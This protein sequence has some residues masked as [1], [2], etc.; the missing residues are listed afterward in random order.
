MSY[1][2][3]TKLDTIS[4]DKELDTIHQTTELITLI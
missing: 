2:Y 1:N 3:V 4:L